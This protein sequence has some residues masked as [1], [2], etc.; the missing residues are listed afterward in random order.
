MTAERHELDRVL[1]RHRTA[2]PIGA[3]L[4]AAE[5]RG[6][7]EPDDEVR[8]SQAPP[9][10]GVARPDAGVPP[11]ATPSATLTV[12]GDSS[13]TDTATESRKPVRFNVTWSGGK[14]ENYVIVNWLKGYLKKS[15]GKYLKVKMYGSKVDFNFTGWQ[16]DSQDTDPVYWSDSG[17]RWNYVVDAADKFHATDNPG[18]MYTSDGKGAEANLDF[19]TGV[20]KAADVPTTTS[21]TIS[22]TP[23]HSL[24]P[25]SYHVLVEGGGKFKHP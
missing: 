5:D 8:W 1:H 16:V 7:P 4:R 17:G 18:P 3:N 22:A 15:D 25:W 21:G 24:Q 10:A 12:T 11:A 9:D 14:K 13:Y 2:D 20:Y 19:K 6:V 23:L